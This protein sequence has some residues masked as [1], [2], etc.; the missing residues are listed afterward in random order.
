[1]LITAALVVGAYVI[2]T[3]GSHGWGSAHT[4]GFGGAALALVAAFVALEARL[5]NPIMPRHIFRVRW[6]LG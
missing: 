5:A 3:A 1:V 4:L 2:V 6:S